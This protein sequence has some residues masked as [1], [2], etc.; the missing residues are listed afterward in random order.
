M[1]SNSWTF[2]T[3]NDDRS[4]IFRKRC[5]SYIKYRSLKTSGVDNWLFS[6]YVLV[7]NLTF[8]QIIT[9]DFDFECY[10]DFCLV[11]NMK[12][13]TCIKFVL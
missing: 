7:V 4:H 3:S 10:L 9:S 12:L 13:N 2:N 1:D 11:L 8:S 6:I 5:L